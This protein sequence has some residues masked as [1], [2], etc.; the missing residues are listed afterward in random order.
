MGVKLLSD[1]DVARCFSGSSQSKQ[2]LD[3]SSITC[4]DV[5]GKVHRVSS[6]LILPASPAQM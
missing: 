4:T 2:Y 1:L 6:T 3:T 5:G